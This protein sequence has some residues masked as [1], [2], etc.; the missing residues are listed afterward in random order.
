MKLNNQTNNERP[1]LTVIAMDLSDKQAAKR[2]ILH[3]A[4]RVIAEHKS[5]LEKLAYK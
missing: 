1:K 5:E 3:A 2:L 4:K